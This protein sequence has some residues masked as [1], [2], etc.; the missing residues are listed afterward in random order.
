MDGENSANWIIG[1]IC[2][3]ADAVSEPFSYYELLL[4][5]Q[6]L[7][8]FNETN[9]ADFLALNKKTVRMIRETIE[10]E[11][12]DGVECVEARS[13]LF[14]PSEWKK[15]YLEVYES[16]LGWMISHCAQSAMMFDPT[17][18]E[19]EPWQSPKVVSGFRESV[20]KTK[21]KTVST[22]VNSLDEFNE[23]NDSFRQ[24]LFS[25]EIMSQCMKLIGTFL[26]AGK[27]P[28]E[29]WDI[30]AR[31]D[32]LGVICAFSDLDDDVT[33]AWFLCLLSDE[34]L[35]DELDDR[36]LLR[37]YTRIGMA[38]VV[39]KS[40]MLSDGLAAQDI[41]STP[42]S[43]VLDVVLTLD[44]LLLKIGVKPIGTIL[45]AIR[46]LE[47]ALNIASS[48]VFASQPTEITKSVVDF[49]SM[50]LR[51]IQI[52]DSFNAKQYSIDDL[53]REVSEYAVG[54]TNPDDISELMRYIKLFDGD[55]LSEW[56]TGFVET[57]TNLTS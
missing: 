15:H 55:F 24:F 29:G 19:S 1:R 44:F 43:Y 36:D 56:T 27:D 31:T 4:L 57:L 25:N 12:F 33:T 52:V 6:S 49:A 41:T 18:G 54:G 5:R 17:L 16:D 13:G 39:P 11:K 2:G 9:R 53:K 8:F 14:I 30:L 37:S 46:S 42:S 21:M 26:M 51:R 22:P 40:R 32:L 50:L 35:S 47:I 20:L 28:T 10:D 34:Y 23:L 7:E 45:H 38:R 48:S 3:Y